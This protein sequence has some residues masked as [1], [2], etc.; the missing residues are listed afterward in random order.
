MAYYVPWKRWNCKALMTVEPP[1]RLTLPI[2]ER[3]HRLGPADARVTLIE[4]GDYQCQFCGRAY[5]IVNELRERLG[6]DVLYVFR[7]MPLDS[8]HPLAQLAAEAA[9]AASAQGN[10]WNMH[11]R[12]FE[13]QD[14]LTQPDLVRHAQEIGLDVE[15]FRRDLQEHA[16]AERVREDFTSG[17]RSGV[18]GTPT[19]FVNGERYDG[20]W[21]LESLVETIEKPLGKRVALL[22]AE[23]T[24]IAA[25]GGI[26]LLIM[27]LIA[28]FWAN[29][30]WAASYFHLWET[31]LSIN[32]GE[33]LHLSE[34]LLGWVNDGLMVIFFL[35]VGLEIKRE[36]TNGELADPR[37]AALP[38]AAAIGGMLIPA[39]IYLVFNLGGPGEAGWGIPMAT[40]I[41]FTL[42]VLTLLGS[43]APLS[44]KVFFTALAIADDVGAVLVI[45]LFYTNGISWVWLVAGLVILLMLLGLNR[46]RVYSTVPYAVLGIGLWLAF[47]ESGVHPTLAGVLLAFAIPTRSPPN[48][49]LMLAQAVSLLED[50]ELPPGWQMQASSRYEATLNTLETITDR[51]RSPAQHLESTLHPWSTYVILPIFALAN[52]GVAFRHNTGQAS[53]I[54]PVSLGIILGL[55][56]GK[57]LGVMLFS[58]LAV[59]AGLA[60]LP[61][62]IGWRQLTS[63]SFL[64]GI[65]FTISLFITSTAFNAPDLQANAKIAILV[66][67]TLAA[68]LGYVLLLRTSPKY[69]GSSQLIQVQV[70]D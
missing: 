37:R 3:D 18:N 32:L 10:Y 45:A 69:E 19:F 15:R 28:L 62:G 6:D 59:R 63:A 29:S 13:H 31:E 24:R 7:H 21:D 2:S 16:Y 14:Q 41:A 57:P 43:R 60:K 48:T 26:A 49:R 47:L 54:G 27:T 38:I 22:A 39:L 23:F 56:L 4:Y 25:S 30:P 17:L 53:F 33:F 12:L 55:V 61:S 67:S 44:L 35:V 70:G 66:A 58:W 36:V 50:F 51:M 52:A 68:S 64:A 20:P 42:G 5:F 11:A 46:A 1:P 8:I 34:S 9:E 40:D 65:G